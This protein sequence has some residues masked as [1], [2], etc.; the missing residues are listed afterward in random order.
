[1]VMSKN[2]AEV[3]S[4]NYLVDCQQPHAEVIETSTR[5]VWQSVAPITEKEFAALALPEGIAPVGLGCGVMDEHYFRQSPGAVAPGPVQHR[6][7]DGRRFIHCANPPAT[8][9]E[10][11]IPDGPLRLMVEKHHS[12]IFEAGSTLSIIRTDTD[13]N[14]IQVIS[15]S[16]K[17]GGLLQEKAVSTSDFALPEGWQLRTVTVT[18]RTVIDLPNPTTAWFFD[19]GTSFQGP[20]SDLWRTPDA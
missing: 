4:E 9:P 7:I 17:G 10:R 19:D 2:L 13:T 6:L 11:P 1:M 8:G 12:L 3:P 20:I 14:L 5:T 16:P 15:A 18:E